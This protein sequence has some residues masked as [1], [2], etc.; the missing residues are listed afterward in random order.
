MFTGGGSAR[1]T[2]GR[3]LRGRGKK[4]ILNKYAL[5]PLKTMSTLDSGQIE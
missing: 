2:V 4:L 1:T 5:M 3:T